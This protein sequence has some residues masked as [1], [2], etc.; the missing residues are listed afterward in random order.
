MKLQFK[1]TLSVLLISFCISAIAQKQGGMTAIYSGVPWYDNH[2]NVVSAHGA[3]IIKDNGRYYFFGEKH[4]DDSNAF[5]GFNCYSSADLYNWKFENVVLPVQKS[6]KL[7]PNSVGERVKVLKCPETGEYVMFM[8]VDSLTYKDQFV[9]YATSKTINGTYTYQGPVLYKG[10]PIRKWDMGVFH[11]TDGSGYIITHSGNLYKLSNNY[12][13]VTEQVVKD[14]TSG[15]EAPAIFKKDSVYFWLG[16]DLTSWEKN[17][18]Y[19][20]TATSLKG[21]WTPRGS[22]APKGTLTWNSQTTSVLTISGSKDTTWLFM[23]D[24]WSYPKQA[25]SATYIW[26]PLVV[27]GYSISLPDYK[28]SWQIN[29]STGTW[30]EVRTAGKTIENTDGKSIKYSGKWIHSSGTDGLNDSR[31]DVKGAS[32]SVKFSGTQ[33]EWYGTV[34]PEGGYARVTI[35]NSK[36]KIILSSLVDLYCKYPESSLRFISPVLPKG[37]YMLT[38]SVTGEHGNWT[39]KDGTVFGSTGNFVSVD[40]IIY[41]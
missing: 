27:S 40:K 37:N 26:Q 8:H 7:G 30:N 41:N 1:S 17:D 32:F 5:A 21:P 10:K 39:K 15:S 33:I 12:K 3:N 34:R 9:G 11:D 22:F 24:R 16:S 28:Q 29:T 25:S 2:G 14:M 38:V 6:G 4:Y 35:K 19:Y 13:S 31:S 36:G 23:G 18:N 20:F